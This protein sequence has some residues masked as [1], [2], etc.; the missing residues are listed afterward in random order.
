M[1]VSICWFN[2]FALP[3]LVMDNLKLELDDLLNK[4]PF[5]PFIVT[6]ADGFSIAVESP[7][8]MLLGLRM[9]AVTDKSGRL[10]HFP[11]TGIAHISEA[12]DTE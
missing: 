7:K 9:L 11:F 5:V 1:R 6:S 2:Q 8:R 3:F 4:E 10:Y 12:S